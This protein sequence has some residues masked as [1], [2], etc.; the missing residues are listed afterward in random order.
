[1]KRRFLFPLLTVSLLLQGCAVISPLAGQPATLGPAKGS[2]I[3]VGGG[4]MPKVIFDRFFEAAGGRDAKLVVVPTAG[5]KDAYD[6]STSS[7]K[8]FKKAGATNVHLLHTRDPKVADS[9]EFV[10]VLRDA[11]ALWF[12]GGR[13][14]RLADAYLGTK[15]EAAFHDV[16]KRGGVI[17]GSSAGATIQASYLVR[18]APEGNQ[19]MMSSG[20]EQGFGFIHNSA[21][22]QHLL[23]RKRENDMLPVIRK[24]PHLLGIGIDESTALYVRG[25]NAEVIGK[26]KVLFYDI[27]LEK[28]VGK[29]FYTT[30][31]PGERYDLKSRRKLSVK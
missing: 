31:D 20:H 11:R 9:D 1:M 13:Q 22:D 2:L 6:E 8:M 10:A 28:T 19:I 3:I 25:N 27:A 21:I 24:H 26:S 16:L 18:G 15:T 30:L 12:G 4:G 23:A 17:G 7:V 14:W 5:T 29:K